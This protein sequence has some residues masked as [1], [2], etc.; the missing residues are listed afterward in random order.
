MT[1]TLHDLTQRAIFWNQLFHFEVLQHIFGGL[2]FFRVSYG[3]GILYS[4]PPLYCFYFYRKNILHLNC[5]FKIYFLR[6]WLIYQAFQTG[7]KIFVMGFD[8]QYS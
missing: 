7:G 3:R 5:Y 8:Y 6:M 2:Y 1:V 4:P